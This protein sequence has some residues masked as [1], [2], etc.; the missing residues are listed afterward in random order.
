VAGVVRVGPS[1]R[2]GSRQFNQ[3]SRFQLLKHANDTVGGHNAQSDAICTQYGMGSNHTEHCDVSCA[4][5]A[6]PPSVEASRLAS[7]NCKVTQSPSSRHPRER[8]LRPRH[9]ARR[10]PGP[11]QGVYWPRKPKVARGEARSALGANCSAKSCPKSAKLTRNR[12][13]N[14]PDALARPWG[15]YI[16]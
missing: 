3:N 10:A 11:P 12:P 7:S 15:D 13:E 4:R 2:V 6:R 16:Y 8:P 14:V 5:V 9:T 1:S